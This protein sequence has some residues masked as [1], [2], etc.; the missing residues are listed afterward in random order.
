MEGK[1]NI[2]E[3]V[4]EENSMEKKFQ[5]KPTFGEEKEEY[6]NYPYVFEYLPNIFFRLKLVV[7]YGYCL[8]KIKC[9]FIKKWLLKISNTHKKSTGVLGAESPLSNLNSS[10]ILLLQFLNC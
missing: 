4:D 7:Y 9:S 3:N 2:K 6:I 10:S 5:R 1:E 8:L